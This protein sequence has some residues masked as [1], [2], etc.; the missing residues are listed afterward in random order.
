MINQ[1]A[2][3]VKPIAQQYN[4]QKVILFGSHARGDATVDS[5]IDLFINAGGIRF[6]D[7][8]TAGMDIKE[9][10]NNIEIDILFEDYMDVH[11][12]ILENVRK[13]GVILYEE[14]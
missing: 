11:P 1:I 6:L 3:T 13:D 7:A 4:F 2:D 8:C 12:D 5:D 9:A 14:E 10:L